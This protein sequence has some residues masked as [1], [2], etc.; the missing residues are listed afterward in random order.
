M[1]KIRELCVTLHGILKK[2]HILMKQ[3]KATYLLIAMLLG[4]LASCSSASDSTVTLYDDAAITGFTLG[5]VN[6]YENGVKSTFN[7]AEYL[8][9]IDQ[10]NRVIY[11][12]DSLP[13]GTDAAHIVCTITTAYNSNPFLVSMDDTYMTYYDG[14]DSIDFTKPR[15]FRVA[16]SSNVGYTDYTVKV[17]VHKE[18]PDAFVWEKLANIPVMTGLRTVA[19]NDRIYVFG[20]ESGTFKGYYTEDGSAWTPATMPMI[21]DADAWQNVVANGDSLYIMDGTNIY[22]TFD[23]NS[24]DEDKSILPDGV[25]LL[26]LLGASTSEVY[27]LSTKGS[28]LT[29]YCDDQLSVWIE[30]ESETKSSFETLPSQDFTM[31]SY[32]MNLSD[33]TDYVLMAGNTEINSKWNSRL[34]R[35]IVDYSETGIMSLLEEY[36]NTL[37]EGKTDFPEWIRKWTYLDRADDK[38]YELPALENIQLIWYDGVLMAF[39]GKGLNDNTIEPLRTI[40]QSRDNG[41]TWKEVKNY[42]MPPTSGNATFNSAATSFSTATDNGFIWIVC[43]GT[44]EVWR[45]RLNRVAWEQ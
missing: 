22:R 39:G 40:Y 14:T 41:I 3:I 13:L 28:L 35:R 33:S 9:H 12:T 37:I 19:F 34:W 1:L 8:F 29:K 45:G 24:W 26:T 20:N 18:N 11:N 38:R 6:R 32:P 4:T 16:S 5:R 17:N 7:G 44:G 23:T 10:V 31:I 42:S 2:R 25:T 30:A 43:A 27:A 21:N 36:I 15:S